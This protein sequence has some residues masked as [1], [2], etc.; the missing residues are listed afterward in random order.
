MTQK[1]KKLGVKLQGLTRPPVFLV[2]RE[3][4][5]WKKKLGLEKLPFAARAKVLKIDENQPDAWPTSN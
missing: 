4:L 5:L 2:K 1:L 3:S